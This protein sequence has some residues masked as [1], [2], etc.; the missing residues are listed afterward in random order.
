MVSVIGEP[1]FDYDYDHRRKRLSTSTTNCIVTSLL[2]ELRG[3]RDIVADE[4]NVGAFL[5]GAR[6]T[7]TALAKRQA[8]GRQR[9][10]GQACPYMEIVTQMHL[11]KNTI[12]GGE[13]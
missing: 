7:T 3:S 2:S 4:T 1:F 11:Y 9:L 12:K 8:Q 13:I 6:Q 10:S 5:V